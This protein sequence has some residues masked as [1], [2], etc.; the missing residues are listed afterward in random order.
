MTSQ[1]VN[2]LQEYMQQAIEWAPRL[3]MGLLV[4]SMVWII[5]SRTGRFVYSRLQLRMDDPLLVRFLSRLTRWSL[6]TIGFVLAFKIMGMADI[7][8]G[9]VAGAGLSAFIIGFAFKDIGENFLAGV[10]LAFNRPFQVGHTI[11]SSDAIGNVVS[12]DLR[13]T[14][15]KTFDGKDIFIP[16]SAIIKNPL[17]NYTIDGY[18]R[19]EFT[20]SIDYNSDIEQVSTIILQTLS[21]IPGVLK[22]QKSPEVTV[23]NL[24]SS[25]IVLKVYYWLDT[26]DKTVSG[27]EVKSEAIH[28]TLKTLEQHEI[29][30]PASIIEMKNYKNQNFATN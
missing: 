8:G 21:S 30:M 1:L 12:L 2:I 14:H 9:L 5:A 20:I 28:K 29:Y 22:D 17:I 26:F 25:S 23:D 13:N 24:D 4:F 16:N 6:I 27:L 19:Q 15:I 11:E 3:I 7:A 10:L 18:L